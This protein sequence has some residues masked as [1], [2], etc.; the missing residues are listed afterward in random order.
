V[1]DFTVAAVV[2][3][4]AMDVAKNYFDIRSTLQQAEI[5]SVLGTLDDAKKY[6]DVEDYFVMLANLKKGLGTNAAEVNKMRAELTK[7]GYQVATAYE[8]KKSITELM[9]RVISTLS[10][11]GVG[12]LALASLGVANLVIAS[13]HAR[14]YEFG[15]LRA[16]GAGR[17]TLLRMVLAEIAM[18]GVVASF[19]GSV[20]GLH[21]VFMGT[22][23]DR[24]LV[25]F[26]TRFIENGTDVAAVAWILGWGLLITIAIACL[27]SF[28]PALKS[29]MSA[30]RELLATARG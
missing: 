21:F 27:A 3:S 11:M 1:V 9:D 17:G 16:I 28:F 8:M 2:S 7:Q 26:P 6:F 13:T 14:R 5:S 15:V 20:A 4:T 22:R 10:M 23:L 12:A 19:L 29:S 18:I 30:Q 24:L 25:G